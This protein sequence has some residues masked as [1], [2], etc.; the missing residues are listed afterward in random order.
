MNVV[1][2]STNNTNGESE[3]E[4]CSDIVPEGTK[5]L[6]CTINFLLLDN[7]SWSLLLLGNL[8]NDDGDG[9]DNAAK[10]KA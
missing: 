10:R 8:S 5:I 2:R 4:L 9:N 6:Y 7:L 1:P 3:N